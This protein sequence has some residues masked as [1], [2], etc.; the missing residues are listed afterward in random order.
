[1]SYNKIKSDINRS[2]YVYLIIVQRE[3]YCATVVDTRSLRFAYIYIYFNYIAMQL[4]EYAECVATN[5]AARLVFCLS[6]AQIDMTKIF[7][8][9][10]QQSYDN[11]DDMEFAKK[12]SKWS[13]IH[14]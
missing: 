11:S 8:I 2:T 6:I 1:M 12:I 3:H 4:V 5:H 9:Q 13:N 10:K 14:F 7:E